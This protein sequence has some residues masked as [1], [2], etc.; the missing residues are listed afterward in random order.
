MA[1]SPIAPNATDVYVISAAGITPV[2]A[3]TRFEG[4]ATAD[5]S[6]SA[7]GSAWASISASAAVESLAGTGIRDRIADV[8]PMESPAGTRSVADDA[9]V[10]E[11]LTEAELAALEA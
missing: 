6:K 5:A 1:K 9:D 3:G 2:P 11:G 7:L 4:A 8:A 10:F